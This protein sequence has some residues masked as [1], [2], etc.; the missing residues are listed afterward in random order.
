VTTN[1]DKQIKREAGDGPSAHAA[2]L[3]PSLA[4]HLSHAKEEEMSPNGSKLSAAIREAGIFPY[5][6]ARAAWYGALWF[7]FCN[8]DMTSLDRGYA[9]GRRVK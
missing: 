6:L 3:R 7:A 9:A 8:G 2:G 4:S 5:R 1:P